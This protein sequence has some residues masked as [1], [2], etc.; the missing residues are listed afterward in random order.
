MSLQKKIESQML[1][2]RE[3]SAYIGM[4]VWWLRKSRQKRIRR[5]AP[6]PT[7][8]GRTVR[9]LKADLDR[10]LTRK[11]IETEQRRSA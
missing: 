2:T 7:Y 3:A 4:S 10:W 1:T 9:Y 6:L 5:D 11:R 8:F